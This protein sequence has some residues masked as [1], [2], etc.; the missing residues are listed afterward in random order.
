MSRQPAAL[1]VRCA[2]FLSNLTRIVVPSKTT[3]DPV[4]KLRYIKED[5]V[6]DRKLLPTQKNEKEEGSLSYRV[7]V[8]NEEQYSCWPTDRPIPE[9]WHD[10]GKTG[11][12]TTCLDYIEQVWT[13]MRPLSLRRRMES[14]STAANGQ[15]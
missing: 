9:G 12:K 13:D 1:R 11:G 7:V 2:F 15:R 3:N 6:M 5:I 8:N 10:V 14:S 4:P